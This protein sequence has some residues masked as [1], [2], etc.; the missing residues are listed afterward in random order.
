MKFQEKDLNLIIILSTIV[1]VCLWVIL[2]SV[3]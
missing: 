3:F 1:L 2:K